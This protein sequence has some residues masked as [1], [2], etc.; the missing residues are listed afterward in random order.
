MHPFVFTA[1]TAIMYAHS[2]L[3]GSCHCSILPPGSKSWDENLAL[4]LQKNRL[5]AMYMI[6]M[7]FL[8]MLRHEQ[9]VIR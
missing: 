7:H 9:K 3:K 2:R 1:F 6:E 4:L 8:E 5:V